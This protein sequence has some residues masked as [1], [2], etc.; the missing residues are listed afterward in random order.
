VHKFWRCA[1]VHTDR[2]YLVEQAI[3]HL[4]EKLKRHQH[5]VTD[6]QGESAVTAPPFFKHAGRGATNF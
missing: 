6:I 5:Y 3:P 4:L 1:P 2:L